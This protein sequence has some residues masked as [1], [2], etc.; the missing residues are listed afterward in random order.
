MSQDAET[1][2][3][4]RFAALLPSLDKAVKYEEDG[5]F[6]VHGIAS[7]PSLDLQGEQV[8][9]D[10]VLSHADYL[11]S[12]GKLN[13]NHGRT[14]I[15]DI[16]EV[17]RIT[18]EEAA[19]EFGRQLE[20]DGTYLKARIYPIADAALAPEDLKT[21]HHRAQAE[22]RM[23][24]SLQG[25]LRKVGNT[26]YPT[27]IWQTALCPQP[28]DVNTIAV[29]LA[30]SLQ[31]AW[32]ASEEP[33]TPQVMVIYEEPKALLDKALPALAR[34]TLTRLMEAIYNKAKSSDEYRIWA[35]D[36]EDPM[37]TATLEEIA[38]D[39]DIHLRLLERMK[40]R[41]LEKVEESAGVSKQTQKA[42]AGEREALGKG[43]LA[44]AKAGLSA[45]TGTDEANLKGGGS[46]RRQSLRPRLE[47]A[48]WFCPKCGYEVKAPTREAPLCKKCATAMEPLKKG[49]P[50]LGT[51]ERFKEIEKDARESG[52]RDPAA[53]A[54]A[55]G[56]EKY[57]ANKMAEL[58]RKGRRHAA[59][60]RARHRENV[61][62]GLHLLIKAQQRGDG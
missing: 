4:L 3:T 45:D 49:K 32:Q 7:D 42:A 50:L 15:G 26:V 22:A 48:S 25:Q 1:M 28:V 5:S 34:D 9:Q 35:A 27:A 33:V 40:I 38:G 16:V 46:F 39:E 18:P 13:W 53:V 43:L 55:V 36:E 44:L 30:K 19:K 61:S 57:G 37:I 6:Y 47:E 17:R 20:G 12:W 59:R 51:G 29:P 60:E 21:A 10:A 14:D 31:E 56:R 54:A 8:N 2:P 62:K 41:V 52:A 58:S 11:K 24:F 23:G